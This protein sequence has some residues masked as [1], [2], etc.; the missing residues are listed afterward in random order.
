ME[1]HLKTKLE[2]GKFLGV[3]PARSLIMASVKGKSNKSTEVTLRLALVRA[4]LSGWRLH[5]R[6]LPGR[7][8]FYF[9]RERVAI[10]V[11]GCFW[12]G[13]VSCGHVPKTRGDFWFEKFRRNRARD[14]RNTRL[15]KQSGVRVIRVW[16]HSLSDRRRL[17]K[18]VERISLVLGQEI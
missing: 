18:V 13:C 3:S 8:D 14:R 17:I 6:D 12:H 16:E 9:C 4:G 10:F 5:E 2:N 7:P 1:R 15:L 11:D